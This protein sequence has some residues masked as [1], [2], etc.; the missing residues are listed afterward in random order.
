MQARG[1]ALTVLVIA[2]VAVGCGEDESPPAP[3]ATPEEAALALFRL[4]ATPLDEDSGLDA[5]AEVV[6]AD[7]WSDDPGS[8]LDAIEALRG[9][10]D[11]RV[12]GAEGL[13]GLDRWVVDL[14]GRRPGPTL[15]DYTVQVASAGEDL[16]R[17]VWFRGPGVEWPTRR[18]PRGEGLTTSP[19][20]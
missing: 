18:S 20:S 6:E 8:L 1:F 10:E 16:W 15:A 5:V 17:V 14:E 13:D 7:L 12:V 19:P 4:A 2:T 3:P 9:V 11:I